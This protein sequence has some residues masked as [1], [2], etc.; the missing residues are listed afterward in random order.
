LRAATYL[1]VAH[2]LVE[3]IESE[4]PG[5]PACSAAVHENHQV[6]R[7]LPARDGVRHL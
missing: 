3:R 4:E 7:S 6:D 1:I 5:S 2:V